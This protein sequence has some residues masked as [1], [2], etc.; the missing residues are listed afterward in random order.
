MREDNFTFKLLITFLVF[1]TAS[2]NVSAVLIYEP[3]TD[4]IVSATFSIDAAAFTAHRYVFGEQVNYV[5]LVDIT[6]GLGV[7]DLSD[8][9][10]GNTSY[11]DIPLVNM[12]ELETGLI[13][14]DI[15][16]LFFPALASGK[17]ELSFC[18]TD[19][20]DSM[21]AMD[22]MSLTIRTTSGVIESYFG[23]PVGNE[24]NGFGI[25]LADGANL[26]APLPVSL[27]AGATGTGFDETISSKTP[28]PASLL[29]IASGAAILFL[30]RNRFLNKTENKKKSHCAPLLLLVFVISLSTINTAS[31]VHIADVNICQM[32]FFGTASPRVYDT[33][34]GDLEFT[35]I[36]DNDFNDYYLN[37]TIRYDQNG[38]AH[39]VIANM[40]IPASSDIT[41]PF[42]GS[43]FFSLADL[44]ESGNPLLSLEYQIQLSTEQLENPP[45]GG[46]FTP[47]VVRDGLYNPG[48][49]AGEGGGLPFTPLPG[50]PPVPRPPTPPVEP[51]KKTKPF[52]V[53][54]PDVVEDINECGPASVTR[55]LLWLHN[56]KA[57]NLGDKADPNKLKQEFKLASNW[58]R[59]DGVPSYKD[60]LNGKIKVTKG[61]KV[62]NKVMVRRPSSVPAGDYN[63][64]D[65]K[66]VNRGDNP[67][68]QFIRNEI[69]ANEDIEICVGWLDPNG[70]RTGGHY[71][72][73]IGYDDRT[74]E[75]WVQDAGVQGPKKN[76]EKHSTSFVD[77]NPPRLGDLFRNRVEMVVSE[78]PK[79]EFNQIHLP[80]IIS[81][82]SPQLALGETGKIQAYVQNDFNP[83]HGADVEFIKRA[84]SFTFDNGIILPDGSKTAIT[85]DANG[86][87][88]VRITGDAVGPVLIEI[89]VT[90]DNSSAYLLFDIIACPC[91]ANL[92]DD[93]D[94]DFSDFAI[95]AS[96]WLQTD[97]GNCGGADFNGD[98]KVNSE[99]V[100]IISES[101]LAGK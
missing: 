63:T 89:T 21:F 4:P 78:S 19:T 38:P 46:S 13:S 10:F 11:P 27:P 87:A 50:P 22:F 49:G 16:S 40:G 39:W 62:V 71:M 34:W 92:D 41:T 26:P 5:S 96:Y 56:N 37:L 9:L 91:K 52:R 60:F 66:V 65:G 23:W 85:T 84:G 98:G 99:D 100:K 74:K 12:G 68:F 82:W 45:S 73:V 88:E 97:C 67:T 8:A 95:F 7:Y 32:D 14:A 33:N 79:I 81:L 76:D 75:I 51:A 17:V 20:G 28:E 25:G 31:A 6:G 64:P 29:F 48:S 30:K 47:V 101:W 54:V 72:T 2:S 42:T 61:L 94:V 86:L 80:P 43:R 69:D 53:D 58:T 3:V 93:C 70:V 18:L 59:D 44:V 90:G 36:P 35:V 55:S 24:N 15:D 1:L 77:G 83:V 57:I